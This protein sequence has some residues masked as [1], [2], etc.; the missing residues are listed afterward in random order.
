M[1]SEGM[2]EML[3]SFTLLR[4]LNMA[5]GMLGFDLDKKQLLSLNE[6]LNEVEL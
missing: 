1:K 4:M 6:N 5:S 2:M 3:G